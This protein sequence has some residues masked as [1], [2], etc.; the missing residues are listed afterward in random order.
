[1]LRRAI[2]E[3]AGAEENPHEGLLDPPPWEPSLPSLISLASA[4]VMITVTLKGRDQDRGDGAA[5]DEH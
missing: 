4:S 1:L 3:A 2:E 5:V